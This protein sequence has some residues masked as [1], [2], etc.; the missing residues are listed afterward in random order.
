MTEAASDV[1]NLPTAYVTNS[2]KNLESP[3]LA[4]DAPVKGLR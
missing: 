4:L 3:S 2:T 1:K